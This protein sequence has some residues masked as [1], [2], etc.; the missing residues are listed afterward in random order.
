MPVNPI[1]ENEKERLVALKKYD[2]LNTLSEEEFDRI[3][4]LAALICDTPISL[5]SLIDENRLWLKSKV[6]LDVDEVPREL[7]FC[8]YT[9]MG[10][11]L[12]EV[13]N[14]SEDE[15]FKNNELV[16]GDSNLQFYAGYPLIDHQGYTLGT[17][18]VIDHKPQE[19]NPKQRRSLALLAK[20]VMELIIERQQKEELRNLEKLFSVSDDLIC[21][22]GKD[23]YF[24]K[25]NPAFEKV[26]GWDEEYNLSH[27]IAHLVHPDD[28][29]ASQQ[30]LNNLYNGQ[31]GE[32]TIIGVHRSLAKSGDYKTIQWATTIDPLTGNLFCIGR[33]ITEQ[34]YK[35]QKLADSENK[36]RAYFENV[37]GLM[38]THDLEGNLLSF[39]QFGASLLG[40]TPEEI[41]TKSLYDLVLPERHEQ[42]NAYL[43]QIR[44][45]G[46]AQG[47]L[48]S[49][50]KDG[51]TKIW[52]FNNVLAV[53]PDGYTY[54]IANATNITERVELENNLKHTTDMLERTNEVAQV[55]GWEVDLVKQTVY[56]TSVTKQIHG[57]P[58][59]FQPTMNLGLKFYKEGES[60]DK[61]ITIINEAI[62]EGK[63]WNQDLQIVNAQGRE[64]WVRTIGNCVIEDGVVKKLFGTF[65]DIDEQKKAQLEISKSR[66]ILA[67][68]VE[69]TPASVAM[70]DNNMQYIAV[71]NRWLEEYF[72]K[73]K[74]VIGHSYYELFPFVNDEGK[75]RHQRILNGAIE[76]KEEDC[77]LLEGMAQ[78]AYLSW[79]MRPWYQFD[80][81]IGGIMI[82]TQNVTAHIKQRD[83]LKAATVQAEAASVAKSEFLAN[84]S[85]EI[86]TPLNGVI[87]FTD[88]V[89]KTQL[90]DTQQQYLSIVNQSA[91]ALLSIIND[92]LDFSKIEAGKLELDIEQSDL[93]EMSAQA[94]DIITYQVQNKGLEMLLNL[95]PQLPR[96]IWTDSVRLKQILI[97]LLSNA[98]KFTERG[99]IELKIEILRSVGDES[100]IRFAVRDTGIGIQPAKQSKIFD[101]FSQ[102][103]SSTTK[104]YGG[105][106]L[107]L[108]ISNKLLGLMNSKLQLQ[109]TPGVGSTFFFDIQVQ[110]KQDAP[111]EWMDTANI[112]QVLIVDDNDNN[113]E[114]LKQMLLLKNIQSTPAK[115]GFEALQLLASGQRYDVILMD[116]HM[117]YMNGLETIAKIRDSFYAN[118][119][120]QPI[121]LLS[122]SSDDESVIKSSEKLQVNQRI[123]KPVKMQD[124]YNA[125]SRLYQ[126]NHQVKAPVN[127]IDTVT[128]TDD[129]VT[130]LIAED[131]PVNML[132]AKTILKRIAPNAQLIEATNGLE[133]VKVCENQKADLIFMDVQMPEMNGY[134]A[135]KAIKKLPQHKNTPI[136]ALTAGNVKSER[137]NCMEAGMDDFVVKPVVEDTIAITLNKWL[138]VAHTPVPNQN[139]DDNIPEAHF[140]INTLKKYVGDDEEL[141]KE[142]LVLTREQLKQTQQQI[143][144]LI[145]S[146]DL[147]GIN[148]LGHKLYG[149]ATSAGL[150]VVAKLA[151]DFEHL[152]TFDDTFLANHLQLL[153]Q[154]TQL[155][156]TLTDQ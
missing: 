130:I 23:G 129:K 113:R 80:G 16:T 107:G 62:Q 82:F 53:N 89:L 28:L 102:E 55:G 125:L 142:V 50:G 6:G 84:M 104:R 37:Q 58:S 115:N 114:I 2:I 154:E 30:G 21:I 137:E 145:A 81:S 119:E 133:A 70:L 122:S 77:I 18:C 155:V 68:F 124:I 98:A 13:P 156:L 65:Q 79:E 17:L 87:G 121:I 134:E 139:I 101:A 38:C 78:N 96:F 93:Y 94:T 110:T 141:I 74:P 91:N 46:S 64:I 45:T 19:L 11:S 26:L 73:G 39:N 36:L 153:N 61:I 47:Q 117:P 90:T 35:E 112:K 5:I 9:I 143:K 67:A 109:S 99:E 25:I 1:P 105:T 44:V 27:P 15:R 131:N 7:A 150:Q 20:V 95:A 8:Q 128:T 106:G 116:Y 136:I 3:T 127:N 76:R 111:I 40:Y 34:I 63:S 60:S 83:E 92:I 43:N 69:N 149:T 75:A 132:L 22:V 51:H 140:D 146:H 72:L 151:G 138:M 32:T 24:R 120:E 103:D 135:T 48:P 148:Q 118:K 42:L 71:S 126:K 54:V 100:V 152:A 108:T 41:L 85:H 97:N 14:A 66:A 49:I 31:N 59:D 10:D 52:M 57:V 29:A 33:D 4:E 144:T 86:R 123:T 12:L 88:L 147:Q 56:W